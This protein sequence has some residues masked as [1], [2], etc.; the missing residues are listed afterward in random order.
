MTTVLEAAGLEKRY[1]SD[2]AALRGV[3]LSIEEGELIAIVGPSG[4]GKSTLLHVLGTLE[5]P[6][7][8]SIRIDGYPASELSDRSLAALRARAIGFVFQQF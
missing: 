5:R 7:A 4:S 2:V 8:G 1:G 3:S 6:T